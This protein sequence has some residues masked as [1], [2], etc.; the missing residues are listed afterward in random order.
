MANGWSQLICLVSACIAASAV[1]ASATCMEGHIRWDP[2]R[3]LPGDTGS[4]WSAE[5]QGRAIA[6][7][8]DIVSGFRF[9]DLK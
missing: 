5:Y 3:V 9:L 2:R 6:Y 4:F 1:N 8:L 7:P